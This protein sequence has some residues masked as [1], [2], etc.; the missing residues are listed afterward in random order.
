[1]KKVLSVVLVTVLV[2]AL[3]VGCAKPAQPAQQPEPAPA[4]AEQPA[5]P[6]EDTVKDGTFTASDADFDD[7]GWK[8]EIS[9]T[10][11]DGKIS[12]VV[13][14]EVNKDGAKK[15]DDAGYNEPF[16]AKSGV[17][18]GEVSDALAKA[19]VEKQDPNAVDT[20]AGATGTS[21]KFKELAVKAIESAK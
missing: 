19:L 2:L 5:A 13:F 21:T 20:V 12:E 10:Y 4:P 11:T 16:K 7:R 14:D 8:A 1:M 6:A 15:R 3:G 17:T 18:V 9:I